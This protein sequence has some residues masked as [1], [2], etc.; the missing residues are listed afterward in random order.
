MKKVFVFLLI[1]SLCSLLTACGEQEDPDSPAS[2]YLA[3]QY[4]MQYAPV[5]VMQE[6]G[7][8]EE[9]LPGVE[10]QWSNLGGGSAM[11]E[12]LISG[13]LDVAFM[14]IPPVLIAIDKGADYRISCGICVPPAQLMVR[15]DSGITQL[16]D[17]SEQQRIAVPSIT[18]IQHIMLAMACQKQLGDA[19]ALDENLVAMTN[20]DAYIAL[21]SG[22]QVAGH[23][24]SMPYIAY[25]QADGFVSILD[26]ED[27]LGSGASIV[28]VTTPEVAENEQLHSALLDCLQEAISLIN[29]RDEQVLQIIAERE[30][31]TLEEVETY[32]DWEGSLYASEVYSLTELGEFMAEYGYL[33]K[34]FAGFSSVTWETAVEGQPSD[35]QD[36]E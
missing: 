9:A 14:G 26:A 24:A 7:L 28:C 34:D 27:C 6:L 12:A 8:L 36:A 5:Y 18:S 11:N 21:S 10:L 19:H 32:L 3:V 35:A 29:A 13:S 31:I 22:S 15:A 17:I 23:F 25:E 2:L 33:S 20:P 30:H 16:S 4:G 1:L